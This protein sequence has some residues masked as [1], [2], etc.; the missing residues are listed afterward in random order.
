MLYYYYRYH[1]S[2]LLHVTQTYYKAFILISFLCPNFLPVTLFTSHVSLD[3][4][5]LCVIW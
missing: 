5:S 2:E 4:R 3:L 1:Q